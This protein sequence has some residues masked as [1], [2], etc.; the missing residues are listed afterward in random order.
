VCVRILLKINFHT[1]VHIFEDTLHLLW[2]FIHSWNKT[3]ICHVRTIPTAMDGQTLKM[4]ADETGLK[5][6]T[7]L[8]APTDSGSSSKTDLM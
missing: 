5:M 7:H 1:F 2:F 6:G 8:N 3:G 4:K